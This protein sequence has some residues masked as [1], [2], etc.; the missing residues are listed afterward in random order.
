MYNTAAPERTQAFRST[1]GRLPTGVS[2]ITT[3][4]PDGPV[5]ITV[6]AVASLSL[7]PLQL[8][9]CVSNHL[10]TRTAIEEHGRFGVSVLG[11]GGE[12]LA[13][14]FA[15]S[16]PDK[17]SG[18]ETIDDYGVPLLKDAIARV[19]CD[20]SE[21]LAGGDHTI[22]VGNVRHFEHRQDGR[23]LLYFAGTFHALLDTAAAAG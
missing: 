21:V 23:P 16:R 20:V 19:V 3:R 13:R 5:G 17:F 7:E 12:N 14:R 9:I 15:A 10:F 4:G 1:M 11:E 8:L 18:V 6:S 22:F 2:V